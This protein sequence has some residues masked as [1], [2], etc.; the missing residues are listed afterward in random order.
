MNLDISS[1]LAGVEKK[2]DDL[3]L[4]KNIREFVVK[5]ASLFKTQD[6]LNSVVGPQADFEDPNRSDFG[7][8]L[9]H[10]AGPSL[11]GAT[12][13]GALGYG[14]AMPIFKSPKIRGLAAGV[15][16]VAGGMVG[17]INDLYQLANNTKQEEA[18]NIQDLIDAGDDSPSLPQEMES[19]NNVPWYKLYGL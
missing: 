18:A 15:G 9:N 19:I 11:G 2:A 10:V 13:G 7:P 3:F 6:T 14:A 5:K 17:G 12:I 8:L 4:T 16:G 1:F